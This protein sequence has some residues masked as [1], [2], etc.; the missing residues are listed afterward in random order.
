MWAP[1][2][3]LSLSVPREVRATRKDPGTSGRGPGLFLPT[4]TFK[5]RDSLP[6]YLHPPVCPSIPASQPAICILTCISLMR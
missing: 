5:D 2:L 4:R 3:S 6:L 1:S